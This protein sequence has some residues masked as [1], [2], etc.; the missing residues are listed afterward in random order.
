MN[1]ELIKNFMQ[2]VVKHSPHCFINSRFE[3]IIEPKH[4][5][6]FLLDDIETELDLKCKV[7][8]WLSRPSI[9]GISEYWQIRIRALFNEFLGTSFTYSQ[10]EQIYTYLGNGI[11]KGKCI[12]FINANYDL[13]LLKR[14]DYKN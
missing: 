7:I 4:N 8:A 5:I 6:Y 12:E 11:N 14:E 9:K 10:M 1:T 3:L 13:S 2:L